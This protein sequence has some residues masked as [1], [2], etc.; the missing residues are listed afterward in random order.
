MQDQ[1]ET[2]YGYAFLDNSKYDNDFFLFKGDS[3][4]LQRLPE[5]GSKTEFHVKIGLIDAEFDTSSVVYS[6]TFDT[7]SIVQ[8]KSFEDLILSPDSVAVV[9]LAA[10]YNDRSRFGLTYHLAVKDESIVSCRI[11]DNKIVIEPNSTGITEIS[12]RTTDDFTGYSLSDSFMVF[13]QDTANISSA[14]DAGIGKIQI[15]YFIQI[16]HRM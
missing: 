7:T 10:M 3:L 11:T 1:T 16:P 4:T 14:E 9:D 15:S 5:N 8:L 12:V 2:A 13:I 6:I